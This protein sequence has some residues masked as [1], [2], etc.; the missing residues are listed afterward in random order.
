MFDKVAVL[1]EGVQIFFGSTKDAKQ[2]FVDLG[3]ECPDRQTTA[4][5][6]TSVTNP[7]ERIIRAG[8]EDRAPRT[9]DDFYL[10]WKRSDH[11]ARLM[12]DIA[13]FGEQHPHD[14]TQTEKLL[15]AR[16]AQTSTLV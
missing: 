15:A 1:Y 6:L 8:A 12:A 2:Y 13:T 16:E 9:A 11:R 3:Y 5:F 7:A 4:D 10:A 14:G